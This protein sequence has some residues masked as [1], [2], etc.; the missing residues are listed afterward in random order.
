MLL[1]HSARVLVPCISY[2]LARLRR[3]SPLSDCAEENVLLN[4]L[5][6]LR[7]TRKEVFPRDSPC[8]SQR[9]VRPCRATVCRTGYGRGRNLSERVPYPDTC[10][11]C[12][13]RKPIPPH[14]QNAAC[15]TS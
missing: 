1:R 15:I 7:K 10:E 5:R 8:N 3:C 11:E 4:T 13:H 9:A 12:L 2:E 6:R 14:S